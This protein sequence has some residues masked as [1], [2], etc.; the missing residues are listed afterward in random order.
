M[1]SAHPPKPP[2]YT[3]K[4]DAADFNTTLDTPTA[5]F[6][7]TQ[8]P[9]VKCVHSGRYIIA[10]VSTEDDYE[11][12]LSKNIATKL[13]AAGLKLVESPEMLASRTV[14]ARKIDDYVLDQD[15]ESIAAE[16][17]SQNSVTVETVKIIPRPH[18]LKVRV[19]TLQECQHLI[20]HGMKLFS[21]V[22]PTYNM[23]KDTYTETVQCYKCLQFTHQTAK[24]TATVDTCSKCGAGGHNYKNCTATTYNCFN[25]GGDHP[26]VAFKCPKKREAVAAQSKQPPPNTNTY[27]YAGAAAPITPTPTPPPTL[28]PSDTQDLKNQ[29]TK[30]NQC[31]ALASEMARGD[32]SNLA[33]YFTRL[34]THNGLPT[35]SIPP[36]FIEEVQETYRLAY[37]NTLQTIPTDS[38]HKKKHHSRSCSRRKAKEAAATTGA[39]AAPATSASARSRSRSPTSRHSSVPN[40]SQED[41][42]STLP[43]STT[44]T[45][46]DDALLQPPAQA[47]NPQPKRKGR[48]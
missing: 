23:A 19:T 13:T 26:A 10:S 31:I 45:T 12:H 35:I 8:I 29:I 28:S 47:P 17:S 5:L 39:D 32:L 9:Y 33:T 11:A 37:T 22:V 16:V 48:K 40:T 25:C 43:P 14:L 15:P 2:S 27:T 38:S 34:A 41:K 4:Y 1:A 21:R 18:M 6:R 3:L 24:C 36:D 30:S 46:P 7:I 42:T 44:A 20:D